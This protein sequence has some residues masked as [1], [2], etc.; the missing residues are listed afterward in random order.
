[1]KIDPYRVNDLAREARV[2]HRV[3]R[4]LIERAVR[5]RLRDNPQGLGNLAALPEARYR[6]LLAKCPNSVLAR[7]PN[8]YNGN[9]S[10][11]RIRT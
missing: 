8:P 5:E 2:D 7:C 3:V 9:L 11:V 6:E 1:M 10:F 4:R